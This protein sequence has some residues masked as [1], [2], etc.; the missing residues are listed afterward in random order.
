MTVIAVP[1]TAALTGHAR[2]QDASKR[3]AGLHGNVTQAVD[4]GIAHIARLQSL[5]AGCFEDGK[6]CSGAVH[7][8]PVGRQARLPIT[9]GEANRAIVTVHLIVERVLGRHRER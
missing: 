5:M 2:S 4:G 1:A 9:A 6:E 8:G 7:Q 3:H